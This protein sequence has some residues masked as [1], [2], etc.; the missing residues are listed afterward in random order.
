QLSAP[1]GLLL[2][3][4]DCSPNIGT[5]RV[6]VYPSHP[7]E[8]IIGTELSSSSFQQNPI[9]KELT[10]SVSSRSVHELKTLLPEKKLQLDTISHYREQKKRELIEQMITGATTIEHNLYTSFGCTEFF[11][12]QLKNPYNVEDTICATIED[13]T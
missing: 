6:S 2:R 4:D 1:L 8:V 12:Y 13:D 5:K 11:E 10:L 3:T 7:N 9:G